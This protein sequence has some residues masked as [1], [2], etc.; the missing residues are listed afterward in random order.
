VNKEK[1]KTGYEL[2]KLVRL[3]QRYILTKNNRLRLR[4]LLVSG[5][6]VIAALALLPNPQGGSAFQLA[7]M[8]RD[9]DMTS[10]QIADA[11]LASIEPAAGDGGASAAWAITQ[12][13]Q[14]RIS[15]GIRKASLVIQK[16]S[17]FSGDIKIGRGETIAGVLEEAGVSDAD[18]YQVVKALSQHVN[19][20]QIKAGQVMNVKFK[21]SAEGSVQLASMSME[22]DSLR[23]VTVNRKDDAYLADLAKKEVTSRTYAGYAKIQNSLYGSAERAGIPAPVLARVIRLYSRTI[24]FQRDVRQGDEIQ[25]LYDGEQTADGKYKRYGEIVYASLTIGGKNVSI[26]RFESEDGNVDYYNDQGHTTKKTLLKTPVDGAR[27]SSGFGVRRHPILGYTKMH[28]GIDFAAPT[29]T[30]IYAAGDGTVEFAG[31]KGGYGN[32]IMLRHN[33]EYKTGYGH[34]YKFASGVRS[35]SRVKQGSVIGYVGTTGRSTGPHLHYEVIVAGRQ[36]NPR[37]VD[38][39]AGENLKG[40]E[41]SKFKRAIGNIHQQYVMLLD[42]TKVAQAGISAGHGG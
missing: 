35:G 16:P 29:G 19:P 36:V 33:S 31:R 38:L 24:D 22:V 7:M 9:G 5:L 18:A 34:M 41:L 15:G 8:D 12:N 30:P 17:A 4:Y 37:S 21:P 23:T 42:G 27:V 20:R 3:R 2:H 13:L 11:S 26:Y 1:L 6:S 32:F 10:Y 28:K 14:N 39:P 40:R 25:V